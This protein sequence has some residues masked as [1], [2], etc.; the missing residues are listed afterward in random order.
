MIA[1]LQRQIAS[2]EDIINIFRRELAEWR[3][4]PAPA[5]SARA[6]A[7]AAA[8]TAPAATTTTKRKNGSTNGKAAA[9][10]PMMSTRWQLAG[11]SHN[12]RC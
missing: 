2:L 11:F 6:G 1:W 10:P 3:G 12:R 8:Q 5:A 7:A 4:E 9:T